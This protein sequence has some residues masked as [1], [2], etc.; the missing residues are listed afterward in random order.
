MA[1]GLNPDAQGY[2]SNYELNLFKPLND[3]SK[4]AFENG[5]GSELEDGPRSP[6]KMKALHSS[7]ALAV[8]FFDYWVG[9]DTAPLLSAMGIANGESSLDVRFEEQYPT[10]LPG[11]PPNLDVALVREDAHVFGIESKFTEWLTPKSQ[12]KPPFKSKYFPDG[13]GV[14]SAVGLSAAQAL[15]ESMQSRK[16]SFRHLGA[17]QL[18]KH[19]LGLASHLGSN[20][21]LVYIYF[22]APG[23]ESE[24]HRAE[25]SQ[26]SENVGT[27]LRF[28]AL[29]YQ[30]LL[31][32]L[33]GVDGVD[34]DYINYLSERYGGKQFE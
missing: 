33:Q 17:A 15:A 20:F 7:S 27:E 14:W 23:T 31:G 1:I 9:Q 30:E 18:L 21:S 10:G 24:L 3:R 2:L 13:P 34:N 4:R 6:A 22:D 26:F 29:T 25:I 32:R 5:S 12:S 28:I 11:T 19:A 8:N 16:I